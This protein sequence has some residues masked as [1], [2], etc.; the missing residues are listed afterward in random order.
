VFT[1]FCNIVSGF[2]SLSTRA[3]D[4]KGRFE[5]NDQIERRK[6]SYRGQGLTKNFSGSYQTREHGRIRLQLT[7]TGRINL[8]TRTARFDGVGGKFDR[9]P[10]QKFAGFAKLVKAVIT[11]QSIP[12][13]QVKLWHYQRRVDAM[14]HT[15]QMYSEETGELKAQLEDVSKK[16]AAKAK[17]VR[18]PAPV[19]TREEKVTVSRYSNGRST[20]TDRH[21]TKPPCS[22]SSRRWRTKWK[23]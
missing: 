3:R 23:F 7:V 16:F 4:E 15:A 10:S 19:K 12:L 1:S 22:G 14:A 20:S 6:I 11:R 13:V 2:L 17:F 21:A 18:N 8:R 5:K 9:R